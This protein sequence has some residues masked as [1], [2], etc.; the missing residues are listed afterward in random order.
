[1]PIRKIVRLG[2]L[3]LLKD[4]YLFVRNSFGLVW[5]PFKTLAVM[6]K[7]KDR[8]QELLILAWPVYVLICG[9]GLTWLGRRLLATSPEWGAGAK[10]LFGLT[11]AGFLL[12]GMYL[13]YWGYRVWRSR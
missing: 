8:S 9:T 3:L 12:I 13:F 2:L 11:L 6:F 7:Q 4:S 5:H 10:G 1:M